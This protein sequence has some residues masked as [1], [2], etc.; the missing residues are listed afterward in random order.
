MTF[1]IYKYVRANAHHHVST[2]ISFAFK[3]G[4]ILNGHRNG[5]I[6]YKEEHSN[7]PTSI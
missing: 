2:S 1:Y 7:D 4:R 5:R 6:T 3:Y